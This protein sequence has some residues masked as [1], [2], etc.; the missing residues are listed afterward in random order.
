[1][2]GEQVS[3]EIKAAKTQLGKKEL[4]TMAPPKVGTQ[5]KPHKKHTVV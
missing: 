5:A 4:P 1:M 3:T 2:R